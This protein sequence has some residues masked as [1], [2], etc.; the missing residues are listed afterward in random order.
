M[1]RVSLFMFRFVLELL[2]FFIVLSCGSVSVQ[3]NNKNKHW[4]GTWATAIQLTEPHNMP[5]DPGL[6]GNTLRQIV[7]VSAGGNQIKL[8]ISN[9]FGDEPLIIKKV[10]VAKSIDS[11]RIDI[12]TI[13]YISF[14]GESGI[15]LEAGQQIISD[16]VKF[17][18]E[19]G[20]K[21]AISIYYDKVPNKITGHPGSRT[22]SFILKGNHTQDISFEKSIKTDHWYTIAGIDV[23]T[24]SEN[25]SIAIL[26]NS[27]TDGRGSGINQQNRW[28]DILS[29]KLIGSGKNIGVLNLG[30]G[31][32]CVLRGGL[33][34]T[35]L[36]RFKRDILE[37]NGVKWLIILIGINDIGGLRKAEDAPKLTSDLIEAYS[38]MIDEAHNK[39]IKVYG[40][41][42]LPFAK[43]FYDAPFKQEVRDNINNWIR[44]SGKYDA[45]IDFDAVMRNPEQTNTLLEALHTGDFLHPNEAGYKKMGESIDVNLFK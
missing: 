14:K 18:L 12:K 41:T 13:K 2:L 23:L 20:S 19:K 1:K 11:S 43:S 6:K 34:P 38:K 16:V 5:P 39:G 25:S 3:K 29:K 35:V 8:R 26:G 7:R 40:C 33:G 10:T 24:G 22:T 17:S 36:D 31:G 27:I 32:N 9:I 4:I 42:I 15:T 30:I 44:N 28:P 37:Q 21:M 45:V